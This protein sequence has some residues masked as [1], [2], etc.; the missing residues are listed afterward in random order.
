MTE[1]A[2]GAL[3][4]AET[5]R[6]ARILLFV[7]IVAWSFFGARNG[8]QGHMRL[9]AINGGGAIAC[10]LLLGWVVL[11]PGRARLVTH[12][13]LGIALFGI[14]A[15][16][17][18]TGQV[19]SAS[20]WYV[21][22]A[23]PYAGYLLG[24]RP[25]WAWT[26]VT[27]AL[28]IAVRLSER[29]IVLTP[30][31]VIPA[32]D[33][34]VRIIILTLLL[35]AFSLATTR[36]HV[37]QVSELKEREA[38]I[39]ALADDLSQQ[40]EALVVA[41]DA[42]L[43]ASRA[44]GEFLAMMSHEIR[45]PLNAVLGLTG[46]LLDGDLAPD[47]RRLLETIRSSGDGL[48]VLLNDILDFS[49][50]EAGRLTMERA[51]FDPGDCVEDALELFGGAAAEKGLD[52]CGEIAPGVPP[53]L[54]GDSGRVRQVVVNLVSNAV[55]FTQEGSV[56]VLMSAGEAAPDEHGNDVEVH[57]EVADTGM[58]VP[59]D[60]LSHLF[61]P[62]TQADASTT[63][64]FGGT[65]LGLAI[66]RALAERMGGR[67]WAE[68]ERGKGSTFHFTFRARCLPGASP[69]PLSGPARTA[70]VVVARDGT[71]A[72][73]VRQLGALGIR[74]AEHRNTE[75]AKVAAGRAG[76]DI[77]IADG[78]VSPDDLRRA[79]GARGDRTPVVLVSMA[80][81]DSPARRELRLRWGP[82]HV[83]V[84]APVRRQ[85]LREAVLHALGLSERPAPLS[86]RPRAQPSAA[87]LR[88]LV[89]EDNPVNQRV[90]LLLLER[91]GYRADVVGNGT[92]ALEAAAARPYD[93]IF[94][95][96]RMPELDGMEAT[97]RIRTELPAAAQPRIVALTANAMAED[98]ESCLA[99]G[100]D[101][102]VSKPV[103]AAELTR[104][105]RAAHEGARR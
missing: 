94:M 69:G 63:R 4:E 83:I 100:M 34:A 72:A 23:P 5:A 24:R 95:D 9:F 20:L 11:R 87:P 36:I 98:R 67:V 32:S 16:A 7:V 29:W 51:P 35:L 99:A 25:A 52:L 102:F 49:K 93:V 71:R 47:Q 101:D 80:A 89:A 56:R 30:D 27:V 14:T 66:C 104:A 103:T 54:E 31:W 74:A 21:V 61:Q 68:S 96:V 90:V 92:E 19:G 18:L 46:V 84:Q 70:F 48:L 1:R 88:V 55:K 38:T 58:G 37:K 12:L 40:K 3:D 77:V 97:R 75:S 57:I 33:A 2:P 65:G 105:L 42:A 17:M 64:R 13:T 78:G 28:V 41:R 73:L 50:V 15:G 39:R 6:R 22:L 62:F 10:A 53:V 59:A 60:H 8:L 91:L 43:G 81:L 86:L 26:A 85:A 44:K 82:E 79:L 45:T 76:P